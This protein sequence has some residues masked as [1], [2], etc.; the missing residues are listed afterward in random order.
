MLRFLS[1]QR[2]KL[3]TLSREIDDLLEG[4]IPVKPSSVTCGGIQRGSLLKTM[5]GRVCI[6][7]VASRKH[8]DIPGFEPDLIEEDDKKRCFIPSDEARRLS[9]SAYC[10]SV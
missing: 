4:K 3:A 9:R 1:S 2:V 10:N 5:P 7:F 8:D 6:S